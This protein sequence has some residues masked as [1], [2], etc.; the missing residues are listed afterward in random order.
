MTDKDLL[1]KAAIA[2]GKEWIWKSVP[3][4]AG[5]VPAFKYVSDDTVYWF[6]WNPI[7][8]TDDAM[9]LVAHFGLTLSIESLQ[10]SDPYVT[11]YWLGE[12]LSCASRGE[13][14]LETARRLI[15]TTV[16]EHFSK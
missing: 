1:E 6:G 5:E 4:Y 8:S 10:V 9:E 15:T 16:A 14:A 2:T 12:E 3:A 7:E 13:D 11:I